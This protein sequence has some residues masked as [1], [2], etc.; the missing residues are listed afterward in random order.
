M[1]KLTDALNSHDAPIRVKGPMPKSTFRLMSEAIREHAQEHMEMFPNSQAHQTLMDIC[2][3][4]GHTYSN[5]LVPEQPAATTCRH[6][7]S[8]APQIHVQL[9]WSH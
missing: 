2:L 4:C 5:A 3:A 7:G 1:S 8:D 6:C 9:S